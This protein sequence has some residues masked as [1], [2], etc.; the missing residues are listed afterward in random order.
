MILF[1]ECLAIFIKLIFPNRS[2][3][4]VSNVLKPLKADP[5]IQYSLTSAVTSE[6]FRQYYHYMGVPKGAL[7]KMGQK[8]AVKIISLLDK[9]QGGKVLKYSF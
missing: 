3:W 5:P 8:L 1:W 9:L 7:V 6:Y 2:R 4:L